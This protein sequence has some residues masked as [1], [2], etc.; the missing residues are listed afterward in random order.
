MNR[1]VPPKSDAPTAQAMD[2][3]VAG[4]S[5]AGVRESPRTK[6]RRRSRS[7]PPG[8]PRPGARPGTT[9]RGKVPRRAPK[10]AAESRP[11]RCRG[12]GASPGAARSGP[13]PSRRGFMPRSTGR[14]PASR[15]TSRCRTRRRRC[16]RG[17][18]PDTRSSPSATCSGPLRA[19]VENGAADPARPRDTSPSHEGRPY[20]DPNRIRELIGPVHGVREPGVHPASAS[21]A[22]AGPPELG[23]AR[24]DRA[25]APCTAA[26]VSGDARSGRP[27][28]DRWTERQAEG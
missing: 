19:H 17:G 28:L 20:G 2:G 26:G 7:C 9:S 15:A 25:A 16:S 27:G 21:V 12:A 11:R 24:R 3:S 8:G 10:R 1:V 6:P 22:P 18:S 5:G 14:P 4:R 23:D 13:R